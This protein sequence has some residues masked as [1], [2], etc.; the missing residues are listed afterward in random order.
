MP[1]VEWFSALPKR[2]GD[3]LS[4]RWQRAIASSITRR[5]ARVAEAP[6]EPG[7]VD[8]T[9]DGVFG[10]HRDDMTR[11]LLRVD[12]DE[13]LRYRLRDVVATARIR[14]ELAARR[15]LRGT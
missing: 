7:H 2:P 5:G 1:D 14:L 11:V 3:A 13:A 10:L 8:V 9:R 15:T 4:L 6:V 12:V